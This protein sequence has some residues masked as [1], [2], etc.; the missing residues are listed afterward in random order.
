[1]WNSEK[2]LLSS[3]FLMRSRGRRGC[4]GDAGHRC[5]DVG[6]DGGCPPMTPLMSPMSDAALDMM[7]GKKLMVG[8]ASSSR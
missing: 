5:T 1:M 3:C 2:L 6:G 8:C 4:G 7:Y